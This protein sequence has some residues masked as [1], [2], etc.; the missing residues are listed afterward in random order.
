MELDQ[1]VESE[2]I[3]VEDASSYQL[4]LETSAMRFAARRPSCSGARTLSARHA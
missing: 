1:I 3:A 4:E 2:Q